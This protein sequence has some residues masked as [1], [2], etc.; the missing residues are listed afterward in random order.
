MELHVS[1]G[2]Q[3]ACGATP[4]MVA[5]YNNRRGVVEALLADRL[6]DVHQTNQYLSSAV[7]YAAKRGHAEI[8]HMLMEA[9]AEV[10]GHQGKGDKHG[11]TPLSF[12]AREGHTDAVRKLLE[13]NADPLTDNFASDD[14][15]ELARE[16]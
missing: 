11:D 5:A 3:D 4:L 13:F 12:A 8:I 16:A 1:V 7:H 2:A 10:D 15:I 9:K 6:I 14:S